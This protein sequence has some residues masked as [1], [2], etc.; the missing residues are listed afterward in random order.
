MSL[1]RGSA[2]YSSRTGMPP[3][4]CVPTSLCPCVPAPTNL[5]CSRWAQALEAPDPH[6]LHTQLQPHLHLPPHLHLHPHLDLWPQCRDCGSQP[7]THGLVKQ[8]RGDTEE[9]EE[10]EE[11]RGNQAT[12][13]RLRVEKSLAAAHVLLG[14]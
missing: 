14:R 11:A 3:C 6:S 10:E 12:A 4:P 5:W 13:Q 8:R 9:E 1:G 7:L 2:V